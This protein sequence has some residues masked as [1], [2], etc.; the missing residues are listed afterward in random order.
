[1]KRL[2]TA[3]VVPLLASLASC[4]PG[5]GG[6]EAAAPEEAPKNVR[7]LELTA[8]PLEEYLTVTGPLRPITAT[9]LSAEESGTIEEI[10]KP[11]GSR[12][13]QG[14]VVIMMDRDL[15]AAQV[16]SAEADRA[17]KEYNEERTRS[18]YEEDSVSKQEMLL[19]ATQLEQAKA[20]EEIARLRYERAAIKAPFTGIVA[21]RYVEPGE[22]VVPGQR[23]ARLVDPFTVELEGS[24]TEREVPY[25]ERGAPALVSVEGN[26]GTAQGR[27]HWIGLEASPTTG[28]FPVEI[29]LDNPQLRYRPGVV[30]RARVLKR[31]L[32]DAVVIPR[33]AVVQSPGRRTVFVVDGERAVQRDVVLG[34]SQGLMVRVDSGVALGELLVVRGQRDLRDG[35]RVRIQE[36]STAPD[37]SLPEDPDVVKARS[38]G[39]EED[40]APS[41]SEER[42]LGEKR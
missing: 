9:D 25:I 39:S 22:L 29:R 17:L 28:K 42:P 34:A 41:D 19:T 18:L 6:E 21:D 15:L 12:A 30:A 27:V 8:Q 5:A 23:V 26:E 10:R 20:A 36:R 2:R 32:R 35:S 16:A 37:G 13:E 4:A 24:C 14:E 31:V 11:K 3:L 33:D 1:M 40:L 7:V 38:V